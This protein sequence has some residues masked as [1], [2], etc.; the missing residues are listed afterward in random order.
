MTV[1]ELKNGLVNDVA[2]L[3]SQGDDD[4]MVPEEPFGG[5]GSPLSWAE[6]PVL[7]VFVDKRR[8]KPRPRAD[9][10]PFIP[11]AL[12]LNERARDALG[13][14]LGRFGQLLEVQVEGDIEY[15]YN[16]TNVVS[17]IDVARSQKRPSG[18]I[19]KEAFVAAA[20]PSAAAVFKDPRTA[21]AKIYVSEAGKQALEQSIAAAGITGIAF[22]PAGDA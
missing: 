6:R 14:F 3:V 11:G 1:W 13:D 15:F 22:V 12:V 10:S 8:R 19:A 7:E 20:V 17:C 2:M 9:V 21:P 18:S 4:E 5:D 16:V